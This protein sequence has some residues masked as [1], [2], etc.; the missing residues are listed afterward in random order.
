MKF[1]VFV[2]VSQAGSLNGKKIS[3]LVCKIRFK[4]FHVVVRAVFNL[5]CELNFFVAEILCFNC[6]VAQLGRLQSY[7]DFMGYSKRWLN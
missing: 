1:L 4:P 3:R 5:S 6:V 2:L 7:G